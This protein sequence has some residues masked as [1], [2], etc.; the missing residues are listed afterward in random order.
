M[1]DSSP[2]PQG[3]HFAPTPRPAPRPTAVP[4]P[5]RPA[6]P[7][8]S[9]RPAAPRPDET[10]V[11]L[12]AAGVREGGRPRIDPG[13][14]AAFIMAAHAS[15]A[16]PV[17]GVPSE[18]LTPPVSEV[19]VAVEEAVQEE[20]AA[21][22]A[23]RRADTS[24]SLV[25][26]LVIISRITGFL[27]ISAQ[28]WAVGLTMLASAYT[29]ADQMPNVMYELVIGGM[30]VTSFLPVYVRVRERAGREGSARYASNL[31]SFVFI[32]MLVLTVV[33]FVFAA[34]IIWT[35][36]AGASETFDFE[37]SVW[38]FRWFSVEI[39]LYALSSIFSGVLNAERDYLWSNLAPIFNNLII[40]GSFVLYGAVT[41]AGIMDEQQA[42]LILAIGNPLGVL[43]QALIQIP[44][45][46]KHGVRLRPSINLHD[47]AL[48][49]TLS[50]GLPT[51]IV[52][53][54]AY[55]T[56]AV[57]SSSLLQVNA[58][59]A[60]ISYYS[61]VWYVLPFS[62][63]AIPIS[64]TMFTELSVHHAKGEREAFVT[65]FAHGAAKTLFTLIPFSLYF[66]VFSSPLIAV[67]ASNSFTPEEI[68]LTAG[69]LAVLGLNLPFFG[70]SS[71]IQ[72]ACS[73]MLSM[74]FYALAT[75]VAAV[76]QIVI[77]VALTPI[78]GMYLVPASSVVY[79]GI[80]DAVTLIRLRMSLGRLGLRS[81]AVSCLRALAFGA[82]GALVGWGILQGLTWV[83]GPAESVFRAAIYLVPSGLAALAVTFGVSS[84][85]GLS[86]APFFD[87][88]FAKIFRRRRA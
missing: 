53:L 83:L 84:A 40:I 26:V 80:I 7:V 88:L 75:C 52:T 56:T 27:R 3:S 24:S 61:R 28:A 77:C 34:P 60:A 12:A 19:A 67:I 2:R 45:L 15:A 62:I 11:F 9:R 20:P 14:T 5:A 39:I 44:A 74:K 17:P 21:D 30:L 8:P 31:L 42:I 68:A 4:D 76:I 86:D 13:E 54:V 85:L 43:F 1:H 32:A 25:S 37:L 70:L 16:A 66:L 78:F 69:Y 71:F 48:R 36:S 46:R 35:Q 82:A 63:F 22:A 33:C 65:G 72:K 41:R 6:T 81:V 51:L 47:P 58:A 29:L 23:E 10:S 73:A 55:P 50:I 38:F 57:M 59:G 64:I 79:Y 18:E 49:E 87:S